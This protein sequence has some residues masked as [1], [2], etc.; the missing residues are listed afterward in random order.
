MNEKLFKIFD[1]RFR[2]MFKSNEQEILKDWR[3]YVCSLGAH[4]ISDG[5][6]SFPCSLTSNGF[7]YEVVDGVP[8]FRLDVRNQTDDKEITRYI[9][10]PASLRDFYE[11]EYIVLDSDLSEKILALGS[12]P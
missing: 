10:S 1:R 9:P 2:Q 6:I 4:L 8:I 3:V 12:L 7:G 5:N 11:M